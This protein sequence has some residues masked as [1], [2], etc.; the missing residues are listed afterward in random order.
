MTGYLTVS[1]R[2]RLVP[3]DVSEYERNY[4]RLR[5]AVFANL[6]N[7]TPA[8][9]KKRTLSALEKRGMFSIAFVSNR[10]IKTLN[11]DWMGKNQP[12]DVL[13]FPLEM[14]PPPAGVPWEVGEIVISLERA[15]E[16]ALDY[17]HSFEREMA[18]LFVHGMLHVLGFDHMEPDEE[19]EMFGRQKQILAAAGFKR[20]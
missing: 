1:N 3:V 5:R 7:N 20:K 15:Q 6:S 17:G 10:Q 19:K 2:Q 18:F 13:S 11:R 16:Q 9:L 12:T 14:D 4:E 8:H